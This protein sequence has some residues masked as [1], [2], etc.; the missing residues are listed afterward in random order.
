MTNDNGILISVNLDTGEEIWRFQTN[1]KLWRSPSVKDSM[2]IIITDNSHIYGIDIKNGN[3]IWE[4]KKEGTV[5]TS[6]SIA[7][8]MAY[9][10]CGDKKMY[11]FGVFNGEEMGHIQLEDVAGTPFIE[12]KN[13]LFYIREKSI[14]IL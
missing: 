2:C 14:C 3:T 10:G 8:N 1:G 13:T 9:I 12:D 6:A 11:A 4:V 5:Y 7:D